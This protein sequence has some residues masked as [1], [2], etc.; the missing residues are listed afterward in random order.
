M[1]R[2]EFITSSIDALTENYPLSEARALATRVLLHF[3]NLSEYEYLIDSAAVI[4]KSELTPLSEAVRQLKEYRPLQ[5]ILGYQEFAGHR[6]NVCGSVLIPRPETEQLCRMICEEWKDCR[7]GGLKVFDACTGSGCI[8]WS[9][10]AEWP[11]SSVF[12]CDISDA[13]LDVARS[14]TVFADRECRQK[15]RNAPYFFRRDIL[16]GPPDEREKMRSQDFPDL[17]ELDLIVSNPPYVCE[18]ERDY[19]SPNVLEHEPDEALFVPDDD[20][21]R[22][23]RALAGWFSACLK[24]GGRAYMEINENY[25]RQT[26]ELFE[27]KGFSEVELHRDFHGKPRFVTLS[28]WF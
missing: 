26:V 6:F 17:S 28:K 27:G 9:L 5:Y 20:P 3:L 19:M 4:P 7:R 25:G 8:A 10:A 18:R 22:F 14:Q 21:L 2:K 13:A 24:T 1:T 12:G 23:Y 16:E 11:D 15:I